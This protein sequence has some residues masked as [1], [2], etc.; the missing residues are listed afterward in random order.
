[1]SERG[2]NIV[3][4]SSE[5]SL[6]REK[7]LRCQDIIG[8]MGQIIQNAERDL[9]DLQD[10]LIHLRAAISEASTSLTTISQQS[11]NFTQEQKEELIQKL[12]T[13][14]KVYMQ[15]R[16]VFYTKLAE[17]NTSHKTY[18]EAVRIK[19]L[20]IEL[21]ALFNQKLIDFYRKDVYPAIGLDKKDDIPPP[22]KGVFGQRLV[23]SISI[24][25]ITNRALGKSPIL[26]DQ[27][28]SN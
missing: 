14:G 15:K 16:S 24:A 22:Q 7:A 13:L 5:F 9:P 28:D 3:S 20:C 6:P 18:N 23:D 8:E 12:R 2:P 21:D 25:D 4:L 26:N 17:Y 19:N 11:D 10:E 1:M 27:E